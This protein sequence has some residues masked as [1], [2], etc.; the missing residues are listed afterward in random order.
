MGGGTEVVSHSLLIQ[1]TLQ[2]PPSDAG[3]SVGRVLE[4]GS[5]GYRVCALKILMDTAKLSPEKAK[6]FTPPATVLH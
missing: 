4:K 6:L 5:L 1:I 2:K 3:V